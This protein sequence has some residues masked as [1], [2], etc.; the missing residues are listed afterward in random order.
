MRP[1]E[2]VVAGIL[3]GLIVVDLPI[4]SF[5]LAFIGSMPGV[6]VLL[7]IVYYLF[8]QSPVLG[9]LS[10]VASYVLLKKSGMLDSGLERI[11][12]KHMEMPTM[13]SVNM[14]GVL[15]TPSSQF[16]ETLEES[17]VKSLV[18]LVRD[19]SGPFFNVSGSVDDTHNAS[20]V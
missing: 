11:A 13:P 16:A 9:I 5:L 15:F 10:F 20:G 8:T 1:S 3:C 4:P 19:T 14:D 7:G 6:V 2:L 12:T 18:P 17:I